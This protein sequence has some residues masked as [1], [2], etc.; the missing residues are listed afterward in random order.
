MKHIK[1]WEG[2]F[3]YDDESGIGFIITDDNAVPV[4]VFIGV[5]PA[6][7]VMRRD[8]DFSVIL[9]VAVDENN[10]IYVLEYLRDRGLPVLAIPGEGKK[11]IV[12]HLFDFNIRYHPQLFVIEDTTMSRP[13]FQALISE[14]RR[15]NDFSLKFKEEKPGTRMSK[16]D[17]IQ[18]ILAQRMS[19]GSVKIKNSHYDLQHEITTFGSRMAHDD[20]ID[21][22]A[23]ACKYAHPLTGIHSTKEGFRK[24]TPSPK[25]WV[26]A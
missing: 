23:Y 1:N 26:V 14:M 2:H 6:T 8:S 12:D 22:L 21:A 9:A 10:T 5:D 15:R 17:R 3:S 4:N 19:V 13:V 7:D 11:G 20:T 25:S 16:R 18:G 24:H